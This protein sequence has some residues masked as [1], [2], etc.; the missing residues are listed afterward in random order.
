MHVK[1]D[2][3]YITRRGKQLKEEDKMLTVIIRKAN[4]GFVTTLKMDGN[5]NEWFLNQTKRNQERAQRIATSDEIYTGEE[6]EHYY[7]SS[8]NK[9]LKKFEGLKNVKVDSCF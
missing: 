8:L 4:L 2:I 3:L 9:Y 5:A 1:R 7:E 6:N